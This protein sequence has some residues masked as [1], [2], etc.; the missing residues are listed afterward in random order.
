MTF[1][2]QSTE[3]HLRSRGRGKDLSAFGTTDHVV[4][5]DNSSALSTIQAFIDEHPSEFIFFALSYELKDSIEVLESKNPPFISTPIAFL[6]TSALIVE[7]QE[8][9]WKALEGSL[10]SE[11]LEHLDELERRPSSNGSHS[12]DYSQGTRP[13]LDKTK[14]IQ[15]INKIKE[16]IQIGDIYEMNYCTESQFENIEIDPLKTFSHLL[17]ATNAP[18]SAYLKHR[19]LHL[20]CASPESYLEKQ[21]KHLISRPI[22]GTRRRDKDPERDEA[23]KEELRHDLKERA[24][25]IMITDLVRNDL[26]RVAEKNSVSVKELCEVYTFDTVHQMISTVECFISDD[27]PF[28][29]IV[30]ATFPMGSMTGAPK[31]RSMELIEFLEDFRRGWFSGCIGYI[32]PN[33]DLNSNV[34]IRS[35]VYD[36]AQGRASI[37]AGGAITSLSD[38]EREYEERM[39]KV[40]AVTKALMYSARTKGFQE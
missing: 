33:S 22:K 36:E 35:I 25:N 6:F 4:I 18:Y 11:I 29:E 1:E 30:Q 31:V 2:R 20:L 5:N 27:L 39:L 13:I 19:G 14:Y 12:L 23:L 8:G 21:G 15:V 32:D 40:E 10:N 9:K 17:S 24:E 3:I 7:R 34:I 28:S 37:S 38:P 16:H 26:S